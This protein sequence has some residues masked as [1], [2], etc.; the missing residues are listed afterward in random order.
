MHCLPPSFHNP[1]VCGSRPPGLSMRGCGAVGSA[2]GQTPAPFI[3]HSASLGPARATR[4]LSAPAACFRPSYQSGGMCLLY[5]FSCQTSI[6]IFC[7]FL[8]FFGFNCYCPS[9]G[10][11]RRHSVST[12]TSILAG[13]ST[14]FFCA[15][16][17]F[18]SWVK[19][20]LECG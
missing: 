13:S 20:P 8:L 10:C 2:S 5:L 1:P 16:L 17:A 14:L 7:Q 6:Q 18:S 11:V 12:Y 4:V 15:L 19:A 3:P 9:F